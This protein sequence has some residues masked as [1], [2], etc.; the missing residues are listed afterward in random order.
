MAEPGEPLRAAEPIE[1][2]W[3]QD[4]L[5]RAVPRLEK[6]ESLADVLENLGI[7]DSRVVWQL[8]L[9][10]WRERLPDTLHEIVVFQQQR[11]QYRIR[12]LSALE[13][14]AIIAV[15]I[16]QACVAASIYLPLFNITKVILGFH[17][18]D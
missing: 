7:A 1:D 9:G 12:L 11:Q 6:G 14:M 8:R 5:R 18:M 13:P 15:G 4:R 3:L 16:V 2:I 10:Q 17:D